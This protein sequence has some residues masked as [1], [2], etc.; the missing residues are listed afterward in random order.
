MFTKFPHE[1]WDELDSTPEIAVM[2]RI[3]KNIGF[4]E[5]DECFESRDSMCRACHISKN[6]WKATI[7]KLQTKQLIVVEESYN[8]PHKI[9]LH[10]N[11]AGVKIGTRNRYNIYRGSNLTSAKKGCKHDT[12]SQKYPEAEPFQVV[13][14][15]IETFQDV[16]NSVPSKRSIAESDDE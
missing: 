16:R 9:T 7:E 15:R 14:R 3:L 13:R 6:T 2:L 4:G 1:F 5:N 11:V 8:R 10:E 12:N